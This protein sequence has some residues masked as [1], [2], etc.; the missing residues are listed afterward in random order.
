MRC[1]ALAQPFTQRTFR[2]Q[3]GNEQMT[4]GLEWTGQEGFV[5]QPL[6]D[7]KIGGRA[8]GMTRSYG[9]L[10]FATIA[11]AGHMVS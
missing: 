9:S 10:T 8:V 4:L 2:F 6:R 1:L 5:S 3:V 11:G 7:W